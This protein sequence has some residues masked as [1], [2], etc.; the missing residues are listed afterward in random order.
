MIF[1]S[2]RS[3]SSPTAASSPGCAAAGILVVAVLVVVA[4]LNAL[5]DAFGHLRGLSYP[6][7][8]SS[9]YG[10]REDRLFAYEDFCRLS[11]HALQPDDEMLG[12]LLDIRRRLDWRILSTHVDVQ[13]QV[14][15]DQVD[16]P[17]VLFDRDL[18]EDGVGIC[19]D[20]SRLLEGPLD[21]LLYLIEREELDITR[22]SLAKVT[23]AYLE[24]IHILEKLQV[25]Q[26]ADFLVIACAGGALEIT[27]VLVRKVGH[28]NPV[29]PARAVRPAR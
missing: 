26:V 28:T 5:D 13:P 16:V 12:R 18:D 25:D 24:Y 2:P 14:L 7:I 4:Q 9:A 23:G 1:A 3:P 19:E 11:G 27:E 6:D 20:P 29:A 8:S 17:L 10:G 21:L 15:L 22:V